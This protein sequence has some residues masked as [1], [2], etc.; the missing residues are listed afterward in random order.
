MHSPPLL[1]AA[2]LVNTR[3]FPYLIDP[4]I[5]LMLMP[6]A[7]LYVVIVFAAVAVAVALV[8]GLAYQVRIG[9]IE[10]FSSTRNG[11]WE[12]KAPVHRLV[13]TFSLYI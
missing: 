12:G 6:V 2:A 8:Q 7:F 4:S 13:Q 1:P 9:T 11:L 10:A 5:Y 3:A